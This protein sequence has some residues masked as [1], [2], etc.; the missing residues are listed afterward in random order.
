MR[1]HLR[2]LLTLFVLASSAACGGSTAGPESTS[3]SSADLAQYQQLAMEVHSAAGGYGQMMAG[4]DMTTIDAC[5]SVHDRYDAQV[6]PWITQMQGMAPEMD[7]FMS[8]HGGAT[9]ADVACGAGMMMNELD[10][11]A[12]VACAAQSLAG[13]QL[14]AARHV[15]AMNAYAAHA[16]DRMTQMMSGSSGSGWTWGPMMSGC[17][18][19]SGGM[20][21]GSGMM[22]SR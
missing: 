11:H 9:D 5:R 10:R 8:G 15:N 12:A 1:S 3:V 21:T 7:D 19:H 6:R 16:G 2:G 20:M 17:E 4:A 18:P 13:D 14:E 22:S